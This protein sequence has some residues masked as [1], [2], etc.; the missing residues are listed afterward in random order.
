VSVPD[1]HGTILHQL[2]LD[3]RRLAYPYRGRE[4]TL[5]D[6]GVT[7][8]RVVAQLLERPPEIVE[9]G[10]AP[11]APTGLTGSRTIEPTKP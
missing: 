9:E 5:T 1:L 3:H 4:E 10:R 6:S 7:R 11:A 8:A 2:G